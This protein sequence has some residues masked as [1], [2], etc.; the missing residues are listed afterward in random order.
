MSFLTLRRWSRAV[1]IVLLIAGLPGLSHLA[2]DDAACLS[3]DEGL[4]RH[5]ETRHGMKAAGSQHQQDHCAICHWSRSL[6]A[7]RP[8]TAMLPRQLPV[9][10]PVPLAVESTELT[11]ALDRAPARAPPASLR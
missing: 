3:A 10:S 4:A 8:A 1:A 7:P 11:L 2:E 6:R 9:S 5:D